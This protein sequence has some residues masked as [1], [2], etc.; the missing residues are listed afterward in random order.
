M[1]RF[2]R[3]FTLIELLVVIS[4]IGALASIVL[5]AL[6]GARQKGTIGAAQEFD[7]SLYAG[8]YSDTAAAWDFDEG[9]TGG[10]VPDQSGN[11]N[12]LTITNVA[13]LQTTYNPFPTGDA[14]AINPTYSATAQTPLNN[15]P[16]AVNGD[17]SISFWMYLTPLGSG[18]GYGY[19]LISNYGVT[20]QGSWK[21]SQQ[22][23]STGFVFNYISSAGLKQVQAGILQFNQWYQVVGVCKNS[24]QKIGL[25][26]N[27][28]QVGNS[29]SM[30]VSCNF[31]PNSIVMAGGSSNGTYYLDNVRIYRQALPLSVIQERY[32]AES[33]K[34]QSLAIRA[35]R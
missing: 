2:S 32:F 18:N 22:D 3:A 25:Y 11:N 10:V 6:N 28:N 8:W 30:G 4:I 20:H 9:S 19:D 1:P 14:L 15:P 21:F 23:S 33:P 31:Y 17:W 5:V 29:N 26:I 27:G 12:N 16:A 35:E 13:Q 34:F 7:H 24:S